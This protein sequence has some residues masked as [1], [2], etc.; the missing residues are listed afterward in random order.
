MLMIRAHA[1][2]DGSHS[3]QDGIRNNDGIIPIRAQI[4]SRLDGL[5]LGLFCFFRGDFLALVVVGGGRL[6][7]L[8]CE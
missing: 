3:D 5:V 1:Q 6:G 2:P 8:V 4:V 7:D